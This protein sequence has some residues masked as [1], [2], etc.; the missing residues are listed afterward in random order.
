MRPGM[1]ESLSRGAPWLAVSGLKAA[2]DRDWGDP[3]ARG[4]AL[5]GVP[6]LLDRAGAF[7]AGLVG[8][9]AAA[10]AVAVAC[11]VRRQGAVGCGPGPVLRRGT[12]KDLSGLRRAAVVHCLRVLARQGPAITCGL[13]A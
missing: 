11:Q 8:E 12:R 13:A 7:I 6:G 9:E 3:S 4:H 2:L 5:A 10:G 1:W